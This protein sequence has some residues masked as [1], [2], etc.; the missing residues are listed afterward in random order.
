[1][2][3]IAMVILGWVFFIIMIAIIPIKVNIYFHKAGGDDQLVIKLMA[4][5]GL[6]GYKLEVPQGQWFLGDL[7]PFL[8]IKSE[9]ESHTGSQLGQEEVKIQRLPTWYIPYLS[10]LFPVIKKIGKLLSIQKLLYKSAIIQQLKWHTEIGLKD[11]ASASI[12][13]G[14]I[15]GIKNFIFVNIYRN[16]RIKFAYPDYRVSVNYLKEVMHL[17]FNC[18]F[19][20][21]TGHIILAGVLTAWQLLKAFFE[22]GHS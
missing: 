20:I 4:L 19:T 22:R 15:W 5:K 10:K 3:V 12:L 14:I 16:A 18:I 1:M 21:R 17:E 6:W 9:V 8:Y 7:L 13:Y 11:A 2:P